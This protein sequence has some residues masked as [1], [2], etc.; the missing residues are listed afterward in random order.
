MTFVI[1]N[2]IAIVVGSVLLG[3]LLVLQQRQQHAAIEATQRYRAQAFASEMTSSVER[4]IENARSRA[5]TDRFFAVGA[6]G[7][8]GPDTYRF[9]LRRD[10][11]GEYTE[12]FEFPTASN[13]DALSASG[14]MVV[15]YRATPTGDSARVDGVVRPLLE[16]TRYEYRRGV[17][18]VET[19]TYGR[20]LDFDVTALAD[21]DGGMIA[22]AEVL[23]PVPPRVSLTI[24]FAPETAGARASDQA[25]A[26]AYSL[27]YA[28]TIRIPGATALPGG[29]PVD[30]DTEGGIPDD[31]PAA[32]PP[33]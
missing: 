21:A 10:A 33:R 11:T 12:A 5:E 31:I 30:M 18:A 7:Q 14:T 9:R 17:G 19:G 27:R 8:V 32:A 25:A 28:R 1:D 22:E 2:L 29:F 13:P 4:E 16:I 24:V 6:G 15:A 26:P 3:G 20:V 23:D